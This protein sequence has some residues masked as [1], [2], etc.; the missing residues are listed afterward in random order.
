MGKKKTKLIEED[1]P[2]G[3]REL[4]LRRKIFVILIVLAVILILIK[5]TQIP[6]VRDIPTG[7]YVTS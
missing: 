2:R 4:P 5:S 7:V 1:E 6:I 3:W